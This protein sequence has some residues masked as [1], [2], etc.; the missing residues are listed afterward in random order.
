MLFSSDDFSKNL[1]LLHHFKFLNIPSHACLITFWTFSEY[2]LKDFSLKDYFFTAFS[3][4]F[5]YKSIL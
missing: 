4:I 1:L 3:S 5:S 2:A